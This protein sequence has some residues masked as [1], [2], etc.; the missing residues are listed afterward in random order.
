MNSWRDSASQQAQDDLDE[1]LNAALPAAAFLLRKNGELFPFGVEVM[2]DGT[3]RH[4]A[5][6]PGVGER[7]DSL[8][9]LE[10]LTDGFR[11][12]RMSIRAAAF[13]T[14]VS[15]NRSDAVRVESE[16]SEGLAI[17]L[18]APFRR[19]RFRR[20][21]TFGEFVAGAGEPKIWTAE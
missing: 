16:H 14:N 5:A 7:P 1:L 6:D 15:Y 18:L 21:I 10:S 11:A 13:V 12:N 19:T 3:V 17:L 8:A 2:V 4:V 9:V 20:T